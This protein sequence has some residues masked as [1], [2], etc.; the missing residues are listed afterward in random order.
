MDDLTKMATRPGFVE[1]FW[2][3]LQACRRIGKQDTMR[4]IFDR[5]ES[6][7]EGKYGSE[8]FTSYKAFKNYFYRKK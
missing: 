3:R 7:Y 4:Q 8:L 6:E 5:M 1:V 2:S